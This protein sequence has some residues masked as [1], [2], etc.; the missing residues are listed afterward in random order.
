MTSNLIKK[1]REKFRKIKKFTIRELIDSS[2]DWDTLILKIT[3][4]R[5]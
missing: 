5:S 4:K 1:A 3:R 2:R